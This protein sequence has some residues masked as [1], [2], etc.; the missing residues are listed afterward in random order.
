M[1]EPGRNHGFGGST[2]DQWRA[3]RRVGMRP[4]AQQREWH[5]IAV[6]LDPCRKEAEKNRRRTPRPHQAGS[7]IAPKHRRCR[8]CE[9]RVVEDVRFER[10]V[11][12]LTDDE[13][14]A[15]FEALYVRL[16]NRTR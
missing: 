7:H 15:Q 9:G 4:P 8:Q 16:V 13:C 14:A 5:A 1:I 6:A 11:G 3:K 2:V 12:E 10:P